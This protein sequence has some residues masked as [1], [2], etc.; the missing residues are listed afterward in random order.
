MNGHVRN[1]GGLILQRVL[2]RRPPLAREAGSQAIKDALCAGSRLPAASK[3][4]GRAELH[5]AYLF[6]ALIHARGVGR[7][8]AKLGTAART[9]YEM[10]RSTSASTVRGSHG[11]VR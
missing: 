1:S 11:F 9:I 8:Y 2:T 5:Q 10:R 3:Q 6:G 4:H 7:A